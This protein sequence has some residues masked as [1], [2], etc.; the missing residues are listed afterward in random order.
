MR[1]VGE[2]KVRTTRPLRAT[3]LSVALRGFLYGHGGADVMVT[4]GQEIRVVCAFTLDDGDLPDAINA[5]QALMAGNPTHSVEL[6]SLTDFEDV[7][8]P[9]H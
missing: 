5:L 7:E 6:V 9:R 1:V 8:Q 4:Q 2:V 3:E